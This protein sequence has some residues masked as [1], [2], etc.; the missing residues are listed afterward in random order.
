MS[1]G[2]KTRSLKAR[3]NAEYAAL[4]NAVDRCTRPNHSQYK[5]YGLRGITVAP[6]F[7]DPVTGFDAFLAE[8][9]PKPS[10]DLE[11][12]RIENSKGYVPGN[13]RWITHKE[14]MRNRRKTRLLVQDLGW[15]TCHKEI[16]NRWG[17]LTLRRVA[18][19]PYNGELVAI[20]EVADQIGIAASTLRQRLQ[21]GW[22]PEKAFAPT[23]FAPNGNPRSN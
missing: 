10:S 11:L 12:D 20:N 17:T 6:E 22:S 19:V 15:G 3:F 2:P 7:M 23:L 13:L 16:P 18:L 5:D 9:G 8:V 1:K 4:K 21:K 14:N